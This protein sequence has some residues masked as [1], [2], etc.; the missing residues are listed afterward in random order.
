M[1][2]YN[3]LDGENVELDGVTNED[4]SFHDWVNDS[5]DFYPFQG[6]ALPMI[7]A[8]AAQNTPDYFDQDNFYP[9][10]GDY[11]EVRG[12]RRKRRTKKG[13]ILDK[14]ERAKRRATRQEIVK[15]RV[16]AKNEEIKARAELNRQVG[17]ETQGDAELAKAMTQLSLPLT[18]TPND[19]SKDSGSGMSKTTKI[20]I[21]VGSVLV[22]G[23]IGFLVYRRFKK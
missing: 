23:V 19:G 5:D 7:A 10:D 4:M 20:V 18:P 22:V 13:T 16:S 2:D 21:A 12:R 1:K 9:A 14:N 3:N 15:S 17:K 11:S 6:D 8:S